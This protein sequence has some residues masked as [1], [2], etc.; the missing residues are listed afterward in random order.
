VP[1]IAGPSAIA[2]LLLLVSQ[3]PDQILT[4]WAALSTAWAVTATVLT[5][6][7]LLFS[8]MGKR[9]ARALERLIGMLLI[10][11]AVQMFLD[12]IRAY[13]DAAS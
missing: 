9:G 4:W 2:A 1:L 3:G 12:G 8:L 11:M 7:P 10:M 13:F 6:S 5:A